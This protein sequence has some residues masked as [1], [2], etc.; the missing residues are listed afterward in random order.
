MKRLFGLLMNVTYKLPSDD[1]K[2]LD[3]ATS[4]QQHSKQHSKTCKK[5]KNVCRF[6][7]PRPASARTFI[8]GDINETSKKECKCKVDRRDKVMQCNCKNQG[9][10]ITEKK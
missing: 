1:E 2:L 3:I 9:Q 5:K 7:F 4:V 8:C 10:N 6:N